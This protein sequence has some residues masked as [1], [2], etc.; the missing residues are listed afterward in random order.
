MY[1]VY[2]ILMY[3]EWVNIVGWW[4]DFA[5]MFHVGFDNVI[6]HTIWEW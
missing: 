1:L 4:D 2:G 5:G 6:D 3:H